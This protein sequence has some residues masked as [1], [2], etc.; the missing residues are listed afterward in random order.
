[1]CQLNQLSTGQLPVGIVYVFDQF[2]FRIIELDILSMLFMMQLF[3]RS[4]RHE[5]HS[6]SILPFDQMVEFRI[7]WAKLPRLDRLA[8]QWTANFGI[9][10]SVSEIRPLDE[11]E[12]LGLVESL[13]LGLPF[14]G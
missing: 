13:P 7:H 6:F 3:H 14:I 8:D 1:M 5:I 11:M 12:W 2:L 10:P 9:R 4:S